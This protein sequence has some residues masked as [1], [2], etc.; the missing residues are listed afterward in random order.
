MNEIKENNINK[1]KIYK[2]VPKIINEN[3]E[4][5]IY[6]GSTNE[7]YL[8]SRLAKHK[9]NYKRYLDGKTNHSSSY[10][11][12][13]KY[14]L[15]GVEIIL[16]ENFNCNTKYE[17]LL[18]EKYYIENNVCVNKIKY[19]KPQNDYIKK[20]NQ[21]Y[22]LKNKN[23]FKDICK[24][25]YYNNIEKIKESNKKLYICLCGKKL[26]LCNKS[27]HIRSKIHQNYLLNNNN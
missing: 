18:K 3:E 13:D 12:F 9:T 15:D 17:L 20:Y 27:V 2:L 10:I 25:Y 19:N 4:P 24:R 16:I 26:T 8:S 7:K 14:K 5:L 22:R 11:L 6:I 1:G 21:E 23:K